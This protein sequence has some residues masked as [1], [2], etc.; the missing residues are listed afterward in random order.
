MNE[1]R[2]L[3]V[4]D[5]EKWRTNLAELLLDRLNPRLIVDTAEDY[6]EALHKVK[7]TSY[8]LVSVDFDL[9]LLGDNN[10]VANP[11]F[12]GM[13]LLKECRSS[14]RNQGCGL[15]VFSAK[16]T[17]TAV[18]QAQ[19]RYGIN[20]FLDK[21]DFG[22][23]LPYI[24]DVQTAIRRA[25]LQRAENL[26]KNRYDLTFTYNQQGL[27]RAEL[28]GPSHRS[29]AQAN[30]TSFAELDDLARRADELNLR[31]GE[32]GAWRREGR[33]IGSAVYR[34]ITSQPQ[35][36]S[37]L[38][39]ARAFA[40]SQR[41]SGLG[42]QFS[43]PPP[44]LSV[45]FELMRDEDDYFAL[46]SPL[47]RRLSQGGARFTTKYDPF[48]SFMRKQVER[49]EPLRVLIAANT[50]GSLPAVE[51]EV[52]SLAASMRYDLQILGIP[53]EITVLED[54]T[55]ARLSDALRAGQHVFHFAGHGNY[56]ESLPERSPLI[57]Q[58]RVLT[59]AELQ[60]LTQRTEL[61]FVFLSCCL[62]ARTATRVGR[63]DFHGFLHAL[64]Q[65]DVPSTLAYRWEVKDD[66]AVQ[67]ATEFY[68]SLW[69]NFCFGQ[70]L[71]GSRREIALGGSG[72]DDETW[73]A[74]VLLSQPS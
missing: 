42:L 15:L 47:T 67:L 33:S 43:G 20:V 49:N 46:A 27:S 22:D 50:D 4:D 13:D 68:R 6:E 38:S 59:A 44:C 19:E 36:N 52:S 31:L 56:D 41:T 32:E 70:A 26:R 37:L 7:V 54:C 8:D 10:L 51:E 40:A 66:A 64:S 25:R 61:Q 60:S 74:P 9:D 69:L 1:V 5:E 24:R 65:A 14:T 29:E 17:P 34:T 2:I 45:P 21:H 3:I 73:A 62:G 18:Y 30:N 63:G 35:I 71:L 39:A 48:W 57:L 53:N 55:Y 58:D 28:V 23:G 11:E 12:K 16:A 72:R